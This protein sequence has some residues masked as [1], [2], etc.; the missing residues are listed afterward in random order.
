MMDL[1]LLAQTRMQELLKE[2]EQTR[3]ARRVKP[4]RPTGLLAR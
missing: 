4:R 2:A 3:L 1:W